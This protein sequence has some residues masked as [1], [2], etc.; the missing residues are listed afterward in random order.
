[1]A[2][3]CERPQWTSSEGL[4]Q[5]AFDV[6]EFEACH[7]E[8]AEETSARQDAPRLRSR[9]ALSTCQAFLEKLPPLAGRGRA[10]GSSLS[11]RRAFGPVVAQAL[12]SH[13]GGDEEEKTCRTRKRWGRGRGLHGGSRDRP[14]SA[15]RHLHPPPPP[16]G[17]GQVFVLSAKSVLTVGHF[18]AD[19]ATLNQSALP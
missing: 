8:A 3:V 10:A 1:M 2:A 11:L 19:P 17:P 14:L 7:L 4:A 6:R 15:T 5:K 16:W 9:P 13:R 18:F 12:G